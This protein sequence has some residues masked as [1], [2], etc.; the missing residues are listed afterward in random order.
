[1]GH[2]ED[3]HDPRYD[4]RYDDRYDDRSSYSN[5]HH[6]D[7]KTTSKG[8]RA[9]I[10]TGIYFASRRG[11]HLGPIASVAAAVAGEKAVNSYRKKH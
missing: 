1:M 9:L 6:R 7:Q 5:A 11:L 10:G 3:V 8:E 4:S 2:I